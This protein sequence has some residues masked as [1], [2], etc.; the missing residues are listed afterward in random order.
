MYNIDCFLDG[1][2][3]QTSFVRPSGERYSD[4]QRESEARGAHRSMEF[5]VTIESPS[6]IGSSCP[7]ALQSTALEHDATNTCLDTEQNRAARRLSL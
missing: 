7:A 2:P 5:L 4:R 6:M 1:H 3:T